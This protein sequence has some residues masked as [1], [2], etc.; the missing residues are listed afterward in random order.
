MNPSMSSLFEWKSSPSSN[1]GATSVKIPENWEDYIS[2]DFFTE[3]RNQETKKDP[4]TIQ[5]SDL[6]CKWNARAVVTENK[7]L[8]HELERK[9]PTWDGSFLGCFEDRE[10]I[11]WHGKNFYCIQIL[12]TYICVYA[13]ETRNAWPIIADEAAP[14]YGLSK[15]GTH[16][17]LVN[18]KTYIFYNFGRRYSGLR[19]YIGGI[20]G[21]GFVLDD[22]DLIQMMQHGIVHQLSFGY[23]K[24]DFD[25]FFIDK[26]MLVP[27]SKEYRESEYNSSAMWTRD[28]WSMKMG[29]L[30]L[31]FTAEEELRRATTDVVAS[32]GGTS[33]F[34]D[35]MELLVRRIDRSLTVFLS[36]TFTRFVTNYCDNDLPGFMEPYSI[37]PGQ[38]DYV[39]D[40]AN[41]KP[42]KEQVML[43]KAETIDGLTFI[44]VADERGQTVQQH[45]VQ[46][47]EGKHVFKVTL[48]GG[49]IEEDAV[50][51]EVNS[52]NGLHWRA[53]SLILPRT[54]AENYELRMKIDN[55]QRELQNNTTTTTAQVT[56]ATAT[57]TTTAQVTPAT[58][59]SEVETFTDDILIPQL[60]PAST[61]IIN[62]QN[63][64]TTAPAKVT[65]A[66]TTPKSSPSGGNSPL[67]AGSE[68]SSPGILTTG[69][70][71]PPDMEFEHKYSQPCST[72]SDEDMSAKT[73]E[74]MAGRVKARQQILDVQNAYIAQLR[75]KGIQVVKYGKN[76]EVLESR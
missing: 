69:T 65:S 72:S 43:V 61:R 64:N 52:I 75:R 68:P 23:D 50:M 38:I 25:N 13:R 20:T 10:L 60:R 15:M 39:P 33:V 9:A 14:Y 59:P 17:A 16:W 49:R 36:T 32:N 24:I 51:K 45:Y 3:G 7:R 18:E 19:Q 74:E 48:K 41:Y 22:P 66:A 5:I 12:G 54:E 28:P 76:G 30:F 34:H 31:G 62:S 55:I 73:P 40:D 29:K 35:K 4:S 1:A 58:A 56:P 57:T 26:Y 11:P 71:T 67:D 37:P 47:Q 8:L 21:E 2:Q 46:E 6:S 42:P 70:T 44:T 27:M 63:Y 53:R